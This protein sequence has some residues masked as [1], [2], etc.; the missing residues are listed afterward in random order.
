MIVLATRSTH[1]AAPMVSG[2]V[3]QFE[4][5]LFH[6]ANAGAGESVAVECVDDVSRHR[7]DQT[8]LQE[9]D[10]KTLKRSNSTLGDRSTDLW[11][12]LQIWVQG[13]HESNQP[14][15]QYLLVTNA[16]PKGSVVDAMRRGPSDPE[17]A[18]AIVTALRASGRVRR[19]NVGDAAPSKIQTM[20]DDVLLASDTVLL[21][22]ANRIE[23]VEDYD[24][25]AQRPDIAAKLGLHPDIERDI[26]LDA[27]MGWI[28]ERLKAAWDRG[29][30]G[31]ITKDECL[32]YVGNIQARQIRRRWMPRPPREVPVTDQEIESARGRPFV[33][34][35]VR[36][37][38]QEDEI[39][40]AIEHWAQFNSERY[41]LALTGDIPREEWEDRAERLR[42]RWQ[43]IDRQAA[44]SHR[45]AAA[46]DR[47]YQVYSETTYHHH[48][49][50]AGN[51]CRE[52]YM[53]AGHY[54]RLADDAR[55][56]W[57]PDYRP[58]DRA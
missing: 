43:Q 3:L 28:V 8:L 12:T 17:R 19:S 25:T 45:D 53:T 4:R 6:L 10:K 26:V 51:P 37:N 54:H 35:I 30:P 56:C 7:E 49:D 27:T 14:S 48:E 1:S 23:L 29:E 44:H 32:R 52:L 11:R 50:L 13:I 38:L 9:Q 46:V 57:H 20:I 34:Q 5:A 15:L 18:T 41:R 24:S 39:L 21:D 47:G 22:L 33:D 55:V 31:V 16:R 42:L 40:Q 58:I 36:I 2:V